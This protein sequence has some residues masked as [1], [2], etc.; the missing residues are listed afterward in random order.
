MNGSDA[1]Q[2]ADWTLL[3]RDQE[4]IPEGPPPNPQS[5][6][7][8][9]SHLKLANKAITLG[10]KYHYFPIQTDLALKLPSNQTLPTVT[11]PQTLQWAKWAPHSF[12]LI[13]RHL[14]LGSTRY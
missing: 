13:Q 4:D 8:F 5:P 6:K 11:N 2:S 1:F 9:P 7:V 14:P 3:T 12:T 10:P